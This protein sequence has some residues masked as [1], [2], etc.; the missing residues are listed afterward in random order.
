MSKILTLLELAR[1]LNPNKAELNNEQI[2]QIAAQEY[3]LNNQNIAQLVIPGDDKKSEG[4]TDTQLNKFL[5]DYVHKDA[6]TGLVYFEF[7]NFKQT[8]NDFRDKDFKIVWN[9]PSN[10]NNL[11]TDLQSLYSIMSSQHPGN[12]EPQ[13]QSKLGKKTNRYAPRNEIRVDLVKKVIERNSGATTYSN[14]PQSV[15]ESLNAQEELY[16]FNYFKQRELGWDNPLGENP[17]VISPGQ[18]VILDENTEMGR[19]F[20]NIG[21]TYA[22]VLGIKPG[23]DE[24]EYDALKNKYDGL[25]LENFNLLAQIGAMDQMYITLLSD[26]QNLDNK[27]KDAVKPKEMFSIGGGAVSTGNK[28][29]PEVVVEVPIIGEISLDLGFAFGPKGDKTYETLSGPKV[30]EYQ[31]GDVE[32]IWTEGNSKTDSKSLRA[33][34]NVNLTEDLEASLGTVYTMNNTKYEGVQDIKTVVDNR[35][36]QKIFPDAV[37]LAD[38]KTSGWSIYVGAEKKFNIGNFDFEAYTNAAFGEKNS[39][40]Y[41]VGLKFPIMK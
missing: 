28:V 7:K 20:L 11:V 21:N 3:S 35:G 26:Y 24:K 32:T 30:T 33:G 19:K 5:K 13:V 18:K 27:Y 14:V 37:Q 36:R 15:R 41:R 29:T 38:K 2:N 34:L 8:N 9:E 16:V 22:D 23:I 6:K 4:N 31:S 40:Q 10:Y 25:V 39:P 17:N 1:L 12:Q